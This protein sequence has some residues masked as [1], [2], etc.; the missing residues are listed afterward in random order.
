MHFLHLKYTL[1]CNV[2]EFDSTSELDLLE[3]EK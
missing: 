1:I 2:N 3:E